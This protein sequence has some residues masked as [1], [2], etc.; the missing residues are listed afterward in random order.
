[1]RLNGGQDCL[2]NRNPKGKRKTKTVNQGVVKEIGL[3]NYPGRSFG[4]GILGNFKN[5]DSTLGRKRFT[6]RSQMKS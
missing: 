3:M 1:M 5:S 2:T 6:K 4:Q